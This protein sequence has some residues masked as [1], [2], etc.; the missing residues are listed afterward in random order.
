MPSSVAQRIFQIAAVRSSSFNARPTSHGGIHAPRAVGVDAQR[1][2][3]TELAAQRA[4]GFDLD[5][6]IEHA[7]LQL[8]LAEAVLRD[9][10]L[11]LADAGFGREHLAVLV[12]AHIVANAAAAP[13]L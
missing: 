1:I 9:H 10:L 5:V 11:A 13:C 7:A 6:R 3:G 4:D 8:D 2:V 12:L